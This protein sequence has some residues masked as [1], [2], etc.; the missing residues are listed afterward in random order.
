MQALI[1]ECDQLAAA[2]EVAA[3][4][5]RVR[6]L[7]PAV[8]ASAVR[9]AAE[10]R[11]LLRNAATEEVGFLQF[12]NSHVH[13]AVVSALVRHP[14]LA[15]AAADLLGCN[16]VRMYQ[17]CIFLKQPGMAET[18]WHS[19]LRMAPLDTN[20][21]VTLWIPLRPIAQQGD[22]GLR[23]A[24]RSHKDFALPFWHDVGQADLSKR[25]YKIQSTGQM[26]LGDVS[27]HHGWT[28]HMAPGQKPG[29]QAR[30]AI[31]ISYFADGA[32]IHNWDGDKSLRRDMRNSEDLE[33]YQGWLSS[34]KSGAPAKHA[35]LPLVFKR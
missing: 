20:A 8:D 11:T 13:S 22:S 14:R 33:S 12:F 31:A 19:D 18:N 10:A 32:R 15:G 17:D 2:Q 6:V 35:N 24:A 30:A 16:A 29:T 26:S 21:F 9:T 7:C 3:L 27:C 5:H 25:G 28:L 4:K 1:S 34:L 23:F